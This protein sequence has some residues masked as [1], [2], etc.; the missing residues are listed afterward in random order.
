M[1]HGKVVA[2]RSVIVALLVLSV[3]VEVLFLAGGTFSPTNL[4]RSPTELMLVALAA[5]GF[6]VSL[7]FGFDLVGRLAADRAL[8]RRA[9]RSADW[10]IRASAA[11]TAALVGLSGL[12]SFNRWGHADSAREFVFLVLS[13]VLN[14][15]P[16]LVFVALLVLMI[17]LK[18][19]AVKAI[20]L[21]GELDEVI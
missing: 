20:A 5:T 3:V 21:E 7:V 19:L 13:F 2:M 11:A 1:S 17:V 14:S 16:A 12:L 4:Y 6:Q 10:I 18:G 9:V 15:L 8:D